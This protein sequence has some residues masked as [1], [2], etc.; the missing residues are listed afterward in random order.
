MDEKKGVPRA[1]H[2]R[3]AATSASVW[4]WWTSLREG[5]GAGGNPTPLPAPT[6]ALPPKASLRLAFFKWLGSMRND[7]GRA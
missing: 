1:M 4:S 7:W 6:P 5:R 2:F 3:T